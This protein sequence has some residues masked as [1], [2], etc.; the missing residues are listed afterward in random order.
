MAGPHAWTIDGLLE[1]ERAQRPPK[2][3]YFWGHSA[4]GDGRVGKHVLSQ[5]WPQPFVVDGI[6]YAT[7][8]GLNLLGFPLMEARSILAGLGE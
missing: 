5:W 7:A 4:P 3:L 6:G 2:F 1:A 8:L